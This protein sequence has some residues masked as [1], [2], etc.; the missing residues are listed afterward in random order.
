MPNWCQN[1]LTLKSKDADLIRRVV[2][3]DQKNFFE[4]FLP[5]PEELSDTI[6]GF[7]NDPT[8]RAALEKQREANVEKYGHSSWYSWCIHNWGTKWD[9]SYDIIEAGDD[10]VTIAFDSAW[11]PPLAG[12]YQLEQLGFEVELSFHEEGMQFC[13]TYTTEDGEDT[14][15]YADMTA[16]EIDMDIPPELNEAFNIAENKRSWQEELEDEDTDE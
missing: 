4:K 2:E 7:T 14:Y 3:G 1:I 6:E 8:E 5:C 11:S 13:G 10:Y 15:E 12:M 9:F 16:D